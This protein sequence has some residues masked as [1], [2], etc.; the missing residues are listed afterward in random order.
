MAIGIINF[1]SRSPDVIADTIVRLNDGPDIKLFILVG[2]GRSFFYLL[3]GPSGFNC[4][5]FFFC[6]SVPVVLFDTRGNSRCRS[7]HVVSVE[8]SSLFHHNIYL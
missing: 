3:L 1:E 6:S 4:S 8:N 7:Q 5:F 2:L